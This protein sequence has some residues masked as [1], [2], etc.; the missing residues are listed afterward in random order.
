VRPVLIQR[1]KQLPVAYGGA[2][3]SGQDHEIGGRPSHSETKAKTLPNHPLDPVTPDRP[4]VH[5]PRN[6]HAQSRL[7]T[8]AGTC[9]HLEEL[10][11]RNHWSVEYPLE[12]GWLEE[13]ARRG[14]RPPRMRLLVHLTG[15]N[16]AHSPAPRCAVCSSSSEP[17]RAMASGHQADRRFLPLAR[18]ALITSRPARVDMRARNP[19]LR[20]RFRRL[21]WNVRFMTVFLYCLGSAQPRLSMKPGACAPA[22][23]TSG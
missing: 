4:P 7:S 10:V 17:G 21:G 13:S 22:P 20:A 15:L 14:D 8:F 18:R 23:F 16:F 2:F 6:G 9:H 3:P 1:A 11:G 12:F 19:C 5:L